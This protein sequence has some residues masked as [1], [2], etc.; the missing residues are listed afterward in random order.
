LGYFD[1]TIAANQI[2]YN[3]KSASTNSGSGFSL[4]VDGLFYNGSL[5]T[6]IGA[7]NIAAVTVD[8]AS[9][10]FCVG[11]GNV[12]FIGNNVAVNRTPD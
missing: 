4:D 12:M 10:M 6:L 2:L 3:Y 8:I 5:L 7:P 11:S 9:N 1:I